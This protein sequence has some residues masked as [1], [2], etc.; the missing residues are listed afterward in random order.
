MWHSFLLTRNAWAIFNHDSTTCQNTSLSEVLQRVCQRSSCF[1]PRWRQRWCSDPPF[2][3]KSLGCGS[4]RVFPE[5][6][7]WWDVIAPFFIFR[8]SMPEMAKTSKDYNTSYCLG[9]CSQLICQSQ[10]FL[11]SS[12]T[13]MIKIRFRGQKDTT[14]S[15]SD[16][17]WP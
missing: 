17:I 15:S 12:P 10:S 14:V 11:M 13:T 3:M 6:N 9:F 4:Y 7:E 1:Y 2:S 16:Q 8:R 5:R